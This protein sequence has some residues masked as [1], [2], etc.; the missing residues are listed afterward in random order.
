MRDSRLNPPREDAARPAGLTLVDEAAAAWVQRIDEGLTVTGE[1]E[2]ADW[3]AADARHEA[4]FR[5]YQAAWDRFAPLARAGAF[6]AD[7]TQSRPESAVHRPGFTPRR[8]AQVRARR[9][10]R[11]WIAPALALAAAIALL[12]A[13]TP[14]RRGS[15]TVEAVALPA[16]C[17]QRTLPDGSLVQLNRGAAVTVAFSG[18]ERRLRLDR[19]EAIFTVASDPDRPF[20]VAAG[21]IEVR[22][23]GTAFNV[24]MEPVAVEVVVTKGTVQL[25]D[26]PVAGRAEASVASPGASAEAARSATIVTAGHSARVA[27]A[28]PAAVP[29]VTPLTADEMEARLAWQPRLLNFDDAPLSAIVG[30][31]NRRNPV[32]L[33]VDDPVIANRRMTA[34]FRSDNLEA[35]V[36]LLESN[37]GVQAVRLSETHIALVRR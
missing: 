24:R 28:A 3:L 7:T 16:L 10:A 15:S 32:R 20:I 27:L 29:Q 33:V 17:E 5:K 4:T 21:L 11:R 18:T 37:I 36:R 34:T 22:A 31:F 8:T 25:G 23:L 14:Q 6:G 1:I 9:S 19:G 13:I 2:F 12:L 26:S 35:F 30:E